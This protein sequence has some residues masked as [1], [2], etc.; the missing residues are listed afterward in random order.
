[1]GFGFVGV[2]L[3][4]VPVRAESIQDRGEACA[5]MRSEINIERDEAG[6]NAPPGQFESKV[7]AF[8]AKITILGVMQKESDGAIPCVQSGAG[9]FGKCV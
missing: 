8:D 9:N 5:F 4:G 6:H 7:E 1:M 3:G 2:D